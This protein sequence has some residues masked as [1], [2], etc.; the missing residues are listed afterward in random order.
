[1]KAT[2]RPIQ[3]DEFGRRRTWI[4]EAPTIEVDLEQAMIEKEPIT[5][6]LSERGWIRAMKGHVDDLSKLEFS[7]ATP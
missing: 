5:V 7:R 1:M 3:G 2:A 6:I 4:A